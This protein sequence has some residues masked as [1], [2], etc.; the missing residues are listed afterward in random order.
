MGD[1][2][3]VIESLTLVIK[4]KSPSKS[5][6]ITMRQ[7]KDMALFSDGLLKAETRIREAMRER[8]SIKLNGIIHRFHTCGFM[9]QMFSST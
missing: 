3:G 6:K 9:I 4:T 8:N 7:S 1:C 5:Y 2:G